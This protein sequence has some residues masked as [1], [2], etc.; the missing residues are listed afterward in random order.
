LVYE[1]ILLVQGYL[2]RRSTHRQLED[3]SVQIFEDWQ[4][5][6]ELEHHQVPRVDDMFVTTSLI[7]WSGVSATSYMKNPPITTTTKTP[8]YTTNLKQTS[9]N[10]L[11]AFVADSV[12]CFL[13]PKRWRRRTRGVVYEGCALRDCRAI[14]GVRNGLTKV[15]NCLATFW[16]LNDI[17]LEYSRNA[18][19]NWPPQCLYQISAF[20]RFVMM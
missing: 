11:A 2:R 17:A 16:P 1:L 9:A 20:R 4:P 6:T 19:S 8:E 12:V 15:V 3:Y 7:Q 10:D 13:S 5:S 18:I 14:R